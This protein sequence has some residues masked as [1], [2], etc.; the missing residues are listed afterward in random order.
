MRA[1]LA[2]ALLLAGVAGCAQGGGTTDAGPVRSDGGT[3]AGAVRDG[4][5]RDSGG[6]LPDAG[7]DSGGGL[8]DAGSG[9]AGGTDS[10]P[11]RIDAGFDA[12]SGLCLP[13]AANVEISEVLVSSQ[14]GAGDRGEWFE[15]HNLSG[16][17]VNIGGMEIE[18][19]SVTHTVTAGLLTAGGFLVLAQSGDSVENHN[20]PEDYVYG[21]S[22]RFSNSSGTLVL[23]A[24]GMEITRMSW[25]ST[26]HRT[27]ASRQLARGATMSTSLGASGWCDST[28]VY[29]MTMGSFLGT[30]GALN[31]PCP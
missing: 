15:I 31:R 16:C 18:S 2:A 10:G 21:T 3:D 23:R 29:S 12:G 26:D 5:R 17:T 7:R 25:G 1:C 27:G 13:S 30:P 20:L 24:M 6:P 14:T 9:D 4:G 28:D 11:P 19:G 22:L 8:P